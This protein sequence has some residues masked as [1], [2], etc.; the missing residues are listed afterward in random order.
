MLEHPVDPVFRFGDVFE[1][2]HRA[3]EIGQPW[4]AHQRGQH[5]E[6]AAKQ[7]TARTPRCDRA[8]ERC[9][10]TRFFGCPA[11]HRRLAGEGQPP[12][13][14]PAMLGPRTGRIGRVQR[15]KARPFG[16][17]QMERRD[18]AIPDQKLGIAADHGPVE[19]RQDARRAPATA[20][21]EDRADVRVGE[22]PIEV[23][24]PRR[25]VPGEI[26]GGIGDMLAEPGHQTHPANREQRIRDLALR[27]R[28]RWRD[29]PHRVAQ[30][31][32]FRLPEAARQRRRGQERA[33]RKCRQSGQRG[34]ARGHVRLAGPKAWGSRSDSFTR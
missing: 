14:V 5:R 26:A 20:N 25:I 3:V 34:A 23:A 30:A 31:Q 33:G 12:Q 10:P 11:Q 8:A 4:R 28:T 24:R 13:A 15:H 19:Q 21:R 9:R 29:Q 16:D 7:T 17:G 22:H 2:E 6:I 32:T 27:H 1:E 18:V